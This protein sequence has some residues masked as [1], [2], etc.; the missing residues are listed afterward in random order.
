MKYPAFT[1]IVLLLALWLWKISTSRSFQFAG[2]LIADVPLSDS[3]IALTFDDGPSPNHTDEVLAILH[4]YNVQATFFVTGRE[5]EAYPEESRRIVAAGHQLGNHSYSHQRMVLKRSSFIVNELDRTDHAIRNAGYQGEI[6]FRPPYCKKLFLLPWILKQR[7][8]VSITWDIEPESFADV[9]GSAL[10][11]VD[12][13][14]KKVH[15]GSIIL[16]HVMY[17]SN[18]E[19]RRSLPVVIENLQKKG[20]QFVT[21]N[22]LIKSSQEN[23]V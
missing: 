8:Q 7:N 23:G 9:R 12:H 20:Y 6:Y 15:P 22:Q 17:D 2:E 5:V 14:K 3:L 21:V 16:L 4:R 10:K 13:I 11:I 1:A 19:S 18:A